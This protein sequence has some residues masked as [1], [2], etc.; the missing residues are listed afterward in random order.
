MAIRIAGVTRSE[1]VDALTAAVNGGTGPGVIELRTGD[2]PANADTA[3]SGTLVAT[4]TLNDPAFAAAASGSASLVTSPS[5]TT[6]AVADGTVSWARVKDS[7]GE[8][9]FDGSVGTTSGDFVIDFDALVTGD[10][11]SIMSGS[12]TLPGD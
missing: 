9:V 5:I 6:T 11:V 7:V 4:F 1:M 10:P 3:A 8:V 12:L 2:Q